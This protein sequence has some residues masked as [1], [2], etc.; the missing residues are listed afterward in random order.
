MGFF[1]PIFKWKP[2]EIKGDTAIRVKEP[3]AVPIEESPQAGISPEEPEKRA[4]ISGETPIRN[5]FSPEERKI[6]DEFIESLDKVKKDLDHIEKRLDDQLQLLAIPYDPKKHPLLSKAHHCPNCGNPGAPPII[7]YDDIKRNDENRPKFAKQIL[8]GSV[9]LEA[10]GTIPADDNIARQQQIMSDMMDMMLNMVWRQICIW[11]LEYIYKIVKPF[12]IVPLK[13]LKKIPDTV[14][15]WIDRL[16]RKIKSLK[17]H[18]DIENDEERER[19]SDEDADQEAVERYYRNQNLS[20]VASLGSLFKTGQN[21]ICAQHTEDFFNFTNILNQGRYYE[22]WLQMRR[23]NDIQRRN[24]DALETQAA[25]AIPEGYE[26]PSGLT[27]RRR[28]PEEYLRARKDGRGWGMQMLKGGS[29]VLGKVSSLYVKKMFGIFDAWI[30]SPKTLC[31]LLRSLF[32]VGKIK[33]GTEADQGRKLLLMWRAYLEIIRNIFSID[34]RNDIAGLFNMIMDLINSVLMKY[35]S[36]LAMLVKSKI[37]NAFSFSID[38]MIEEHMKNPTAC[39]P[40]KELLYLTADYIKKLIKEISFYLLKFITNAKAINYNAAKTLGKAEW[41]LK[42]N[43][44]IYIID[45]LLGF[46]RVWELCEEGPKEA[47]GESITIPP[48]LTDD[49]EDIDDTL[50]KAEKAPSTTSR[51]GI[52]GIKAKAP[53]QNLADV[54]KK[55]QTEIEKKKE[56]LEKRDYID[57]VSQ[58][59]E[60]DKPWMRIFLTNYMGMSKEGAEKVLEDKGDDCCENVMSDIALLAI[61]QS[62]EKSEK[63]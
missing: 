58:P 49:E 31:C 26:A 20:D 53:G 13:P 42:I 32:N 33:I 54:I 61:K 45:K 15:K 14:K 30:D 39:L 63:V 62:L 6:M 5:N 36:A 8:D 56:E 22:P 24:I 38:K 46:M 2:K 19:I 55:A 18:Q 16:K 34:M 37:T 10:I 9:S 28:L 25:T 50:Q 27:F 1:S 40:W 41:L 51:R 57:R 47:G 29:D 52:E 11:L 44:F 59:W 48:P 35:I 60:I 23:V 12:K 7:T 4:P 43:K 3:E 17:T 21:I